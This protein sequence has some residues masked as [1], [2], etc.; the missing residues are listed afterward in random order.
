MYT[1]KY[2][3]KLKFIKIFNIGGAVAIDIAIRQEISQ[4][5]WCL[6][7]ENT[8]TSIPDMATNLIKSKIMQYL[9]LFC[10]KNKVGIC[11][12]NCKKIFIYFQ[13]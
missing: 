8:F 3:S 5:I 1:C 11:M 10:Y 12:E 9:P 6:I 4:R 7:V 2:N 13:F